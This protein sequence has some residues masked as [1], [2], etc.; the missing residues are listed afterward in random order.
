MVTSLVSMARDA[1]P[2]TDVAMTG[3]V[4][5][6]GRVLPVGGIKEKVIAARRSGVSH[7]VMPK[8]N[9]RDFVELPGNLQAGITAHFATTYDDV[10]AVA[11]ADDLPAP[12]PAAAGA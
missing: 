9:E 3:E 6:T 7:I 1:A 12:S 2:R 5:L 11:F 10:Y 4:T 8:A